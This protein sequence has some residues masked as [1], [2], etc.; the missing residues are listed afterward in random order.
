MRALIIVI[1]WLAV[2]SPAGAATQSVLVT[3]LDHSTEIFPYLGETKSN[4]IVEVYGRP[5]LLPLTNIISLQIYSAAARYTSSEIV[6]AS[7]TAVT[8]IYKSFLS[9]INGIFNRWISA[10]LAAL[11][12]IRA[13]YRFRREGDFQTHRFVFAIYLAS[14]AVLIV[15]GMAGWG[16]AY[17]PMGGLLLVLFSASFTLTAIWSNAEAGFISGW[18]C[19]C[20][21]LLPG[22]G[23]DR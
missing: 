22:P 17:R 8:G 12:F 21:P 5:V 23:W 11:F 3:G 19:W 10:F 4:L 1:L 18:Q 15:I 9:R 7:K 20:W 6:A 2:L 13:M 16:G 14:L